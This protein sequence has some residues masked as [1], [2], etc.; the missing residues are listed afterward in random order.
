MAES[1]TKHIRDTDLRLVLET[2]KGVGNIL[3]LSERHAP[4]TEKNTYTMN[5]VTMYCGKNKTNTHKML[6]IRVL[7]N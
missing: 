3:A 6:S 5:D 1:G 7:M 4:D 2:D